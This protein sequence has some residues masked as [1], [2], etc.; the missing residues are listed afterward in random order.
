MSA[1]IYFEILLEVIRPTLLINNFSKSTSF[2][3][4]EAQFLE[5]I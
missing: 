5:I 3:Q 1:L 4:I 2:A